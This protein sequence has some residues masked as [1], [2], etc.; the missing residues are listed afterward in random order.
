M[1]VVAR[2]PGWQ[3]GLSGLYLAVRTARMLRTSLTVGTIMLKLWLTP[4]RAR[5]D[6]EYVQ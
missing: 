4:P 5:I 6:A 2:L 3:I 1:T